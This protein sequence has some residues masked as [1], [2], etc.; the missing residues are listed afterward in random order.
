[1]GRSRPLLR[2]YVGPEFTTYQ[3][4]CAA[5][6]DDDEEKQLAVQISANTK[7]VEARCRNGHEHL[8]VRVVPSNPA[9]PVAEEASP[10]AVLADR[11]SRFEL[12]VAG[13]EFPAGGGDSANWLRMRM[14]AS[15][16]SEHWSVV[17]PCLETWDLLWL[18][19]WVDAIAAGRR[20]DSEV[21]FIDPNLEFR[22]VRSDSRGH[23]IRVQLSHEYLPPQILPSTYRKSM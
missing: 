15:F 22:H 19:D 6:P 9:F 17:D 21:T 13:Y 23:K 18:A 10:P 4:Y 16:G 7:F 12:S 8:I 2:T 3:A 5:C 14:S 11:N 20:V 1:M